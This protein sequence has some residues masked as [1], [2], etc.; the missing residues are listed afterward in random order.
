MNYSYGNATPGW[1]SKRKH[2]LATRLT[3]LI[4]EFATNE[5][6]VSRDAPPYVEVDPERGVVSIRRLTNL[7]NNLADKLT[8]QADAVYTEVMDLRS[9]KSGLPQNPI[10]IS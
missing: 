9:S 8:S 10:G 7:S 6:G 5:T 3:A 2:V 4:E 1:K